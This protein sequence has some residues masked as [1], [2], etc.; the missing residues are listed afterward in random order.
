MEK[1]KRVLRKLKTQ[2]NIPK[3]TKTYSLAKPRSRLPMSLRRPEDER[4]YIYYRKAGLTKPLVN[5]PRMKE[6]Q[7]WA[8]IHNEF[9]YSSAFKVSHMLIPKRVATRDELTQAELKEL[10]QVITELSQDYD[11]YMVN[12]VSKQSIKYHY[13]VHFLTYH[14]DRRDARI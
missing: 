10:D 12:F 6:W 9:P 1:T 3:F 7:Y 4:R 2:N 14:D 8:L 11:C 13:H 5:E